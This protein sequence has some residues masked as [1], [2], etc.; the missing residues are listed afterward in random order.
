M[1]M[2]PC[3]AVHGGMGALKGEDIMIMVSRGGKTAELLPI[4]DA[5]CKKEATLIAVTE[6]MKSPLANYLNLKIPQSFYFTLQQ[7]R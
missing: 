2:P 6:N 7:K 1:F 4:I 5:C 3:E